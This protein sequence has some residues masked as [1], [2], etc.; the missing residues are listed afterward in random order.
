M[1]CAAKNKELDVTSAAIAAAEKALAESDIK[2]SPLPLD[3]Y[4]DTPHARL[5]EGAEAI[6]TLRR[7]R[8]QLVLANEKRQRCA[9]FHDNL[10]LSK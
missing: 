10:S 5:V 6:V 9:K 1:G 3:C 8:E 2:L 4:I 7:E